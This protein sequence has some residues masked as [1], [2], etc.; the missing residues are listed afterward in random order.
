MFCLGS[1]LRPPVWLDHESSESSVFTA[2]AGGWH[3]AALH[4]RWRGPGMQTQSQVSHVTNEGPAL[5]CSQGPW[6]WPTSPHPV[7]VLSDTDQ[8]F[9]KVAERVLMR[10]QEK[11]KGVEEGTVLSVGGQVNLL[12]QQ[13]MD[14]K[15][16]SR[17]F[18]GWKAWVWSSTWISLQLSL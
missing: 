16:L 15:N 7:F 11:L 8:S 13:A 1:P 17:L 5:P 3:W 10:L 2:E 9:N 12:I 14:P 6:N 18:P 4:S